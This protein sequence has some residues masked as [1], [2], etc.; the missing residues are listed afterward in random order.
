MP[1]YTQ[2]MFLYDK[3]SDKTEGNSFFI[4]RHL[5]LSVFLKPL[6]KFQ[7]DR[8][9]E[10]RKL[11][12]EDKSARKEIFVLKNG[13]KAVKQQFTRNFF[14]TFIRLLVSL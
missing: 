4:I 9:M 11:D 5:V 2:Y 13:N 8:T 12:R 14:P 1:H 7:S 6:A 10:E 3:N